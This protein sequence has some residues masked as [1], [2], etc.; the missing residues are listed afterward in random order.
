MHVTVQSSFA[1]F[2]SGQ[3][4]D[5]WILEL[6]GAGLSAPEVDFGQVEDFYAD[7]A[8][9][10]FQIKRSF[11]DTEKSFDFAGQLRDFVQ[12]VVNIIEEA[13]RSYP[14]LVFDRQNHISTAVKNMHKQLDLIV[15]YDWDFDNYLEEDVPAAVRCHFLSY[16]RLSSEKFCSIISI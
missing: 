7:T 13:E 14:L 11:S 15:K 9:K 6:R 1:R 12:N 3:G 8:N 2:M 4:Y 5:T 10:S 16:K